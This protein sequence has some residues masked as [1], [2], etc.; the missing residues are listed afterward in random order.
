MSQSARL[1]R[2]HPLVIQ[3]SHAAEYLDRMGISIEG[4]DK[5]LEA[6]ENAAGNTN[7]YAPVIAAG[8]QR[9][10]QTVTVWREELA[11][12]REWT[13]NDPQNRP[14]A[15]DPTGTYQ[16]SVAGGN[17]RTGDLDPGT[18]PQA[19]RRKGRATAESVDRNQQVLFGIGAVLPVEQPVTDSD[20]PPSG[21]WV[22]LYYRADGEIRRELSHPSGF[23]RDAG[24]FTGWDV[25]VVLTPIQKPAT[26]QLKPSDVGGEDVDF[27]I[28]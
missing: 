13:H 11:K 4:I 24:Q 22:L 12:D 20:Q 15:T 17:D 16:V 7:S 8:I 25:R 10:I 19:A 21:G 5:A 18:V 9:W 26:V 3:P 27:N 23:D 14:I 28:A 2:R 1:P 6:G